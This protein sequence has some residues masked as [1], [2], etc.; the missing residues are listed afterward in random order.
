MD[1][2]RNGV[3]MKRRLPYTVS[4]W[5]LITWLPNLF[6]RALHWFLGTDELPKGRHKPYGMD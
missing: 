5:R 2:T 1:L 3:P 4:W 6:L